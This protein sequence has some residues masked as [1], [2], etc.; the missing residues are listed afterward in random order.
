MYL[1]TEIPKYDKIGII[2]KRFFWS[3]DTSDIK[4]KM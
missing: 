2:M 1:N 4:Y 3:G